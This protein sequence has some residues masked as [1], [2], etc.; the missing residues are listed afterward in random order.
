MVE[1]KKN[2]PD[3]NGITSVTLR[4][5]IIKGELAT[6]EKVVTVEMGK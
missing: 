5:D 4:V 3:Y 1:L 2:L 6:D